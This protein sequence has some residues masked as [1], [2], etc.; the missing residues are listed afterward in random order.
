M[1]IGGSINKTKAYLIGQIGKN[2]AVEDNYLCLADIFK[3]VYS[4][5][6]LARELVGGRTV[7]LECERIEKLQRLYETHEFKLLKDEKSD[8]LVTMYRVIK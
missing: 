4:D 2:E 1:G 7:I 3:E 8:R 6:E 5:I